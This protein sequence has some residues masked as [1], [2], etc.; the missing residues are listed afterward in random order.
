VDP[1]PFCPIGGRR[2]KKD[3]LISAPNLSSAWGAPHCV[4][5]ADYRL[6]PQ[7]KLPEIIEDVRDFMRWVRE[8]GPELFHADATKVIVAGSSAGGYLTMM[9]GILEPRPKGRGP[10]HPTPRRLPRARRLSS[11][12]DYCM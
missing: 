4:V 10:G 1:V 8:K 12:E 6:A 2:H 7:A 5:S 9:T 3:H 11:I